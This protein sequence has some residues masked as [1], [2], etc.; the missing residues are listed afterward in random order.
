MKRVLPL[1]LITATAHAG[2]SPA[3][4]EFDRGRT[5]L[6]AGK[7]ADAC[8]AFDASDKLDP[9]ITTELN[10]GDCREKNNQLA[11][12]WATF[13]AIAAKTAA[14]TDDKGKKFHKVA[15][16]HAAKLEAKLSHLTV[17]AASPVTGLEVR[18]GGAAVELGATQPIDG[19]SYTITARAPGHRDWS[20]TVV[21]APASDQKTVEVPALDA[22]VVAPPPVAPAPVASPG[23]GM[24]PYVAAGGSLAL[25]GVALGFEL[26]ARDVYDQAKREPDDM[27]Q[28]SLWDSANTRRHVAQGFAVGGIACAGVAVWLWLR[29]PVETRPTPVARIAVEPMG[30][31]GLQLHGAW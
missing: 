20:V 5:L 30:I 21:V 23:R 14:A 12:A 8:A 28:L 6:E 9:Q 29:G 19:G 22:I 26:S 7:F 31:A 13:K 18:R 11:T 15:V 27:K 25:F 1:L 24:W 4:V 3:D 2:P 17:R 16:D 10:Q